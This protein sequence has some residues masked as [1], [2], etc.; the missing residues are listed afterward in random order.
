VKAARQKPDIVSIS[1]IAGFGLFDGKEVGASVLVSSTCNHE[2]AQKEASFLAQ[3]FWNLREH[4]LL[5]PISINEALDRAM[6]IPGGPVVF[7]DGGDNISAGAAGDTTFILQALIE[8]GVSSAALAVIRDP[9]AVEKAIRAGVG[10]KITMEIGGKIDTVNSRPLKV[11][12]VVKLISEGKYIYKGPL[13]TGTEANMGKTAGLRIGSIDVILTENMVEVYDPEIFRS[14]GIE[15]KDKKIV[16]LK[17]GVHFPASYG[18]IAKATFHIDSPGFSSWN[19]AKLNYK[20]IP[21]PIFPLDKEVRFPKQ[22][23]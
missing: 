13:K 6:E 10:K 2:L 23:E 5:K 19:F 21:R 20:N 16:V 18:P 3:E 12:G 14:N 11:T 4:F 15:P 17:E 22:K 1:I 9:E 7:S 8:R